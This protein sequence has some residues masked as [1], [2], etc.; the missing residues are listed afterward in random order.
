MAGTIELIAANLAGV[1]EKY[2]P[3]LAK[4]LLLTGHPIAA[5]TLEAI[6]KLYPGVA[7]ENLANTIQNDPDAQIKL[8]SIQ[9]VVYQNEVTDRGSA[10]ER[11][12]AFLQVGK[13]DWVPSLLALGV[14]VLWGIIQAYGIIHPA[15]SIDL[16]SARAQDI[17]VMIIGYYFGS[18]APKRSL[19]PKG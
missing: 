12:I 5:G 14:L 15:P 9:S 1:V 13:R 17:L 11:E 2:S 10:R 18:S 6:S 19:P 4:G 16:I 8:A 7:P 3:V